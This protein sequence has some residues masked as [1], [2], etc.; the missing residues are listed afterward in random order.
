MTSSKTSVRSVAAFTVAAVALVLGACASRGTEPVAELAA[1]RA[2]ASQA[3]S[4]GALQFAPV[5]LLAARD[6]LGRAESAVREE[7]FTEARRFAEQAAADAELAER[8]ARAMKATR[9][10]DE[11]AR[12]NAALE[13][14]IARTT[15]P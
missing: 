7:R 14:E 13:N 15:R 4:A 12:A 2:S 11:L 9:A 3:E 8:K 5:E 1:A 6:K 10:V